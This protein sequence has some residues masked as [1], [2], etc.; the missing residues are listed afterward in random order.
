MTHFAR[1]GCL[2]TP[3]RD[4][5]ATTLID[6]A[7]EDRFALEHL[8]SIEGAPHSVLGFHAQQAVEKFLKAVLMKRSISFQ[9]SHDLRYLAEIFDSEGIEMPVSVDDVDALTDYAV[10]LRYEAPVNTPELDIVA[11]QRMIETLDQWAAKMVL[12]QR[13]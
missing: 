6:R 12:D 4:R 8:A 10:P 2:L 9:R 11:A 13:L 7:R 5:L 3:E 1:D